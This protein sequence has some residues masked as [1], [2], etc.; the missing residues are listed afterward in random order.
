MFGRITSEFQC[1]AKIRIE[2]FI[3]EGQNSNVWKDKIK[4]PVIGKIRAQR[5]CLQ[6]QGQNSKG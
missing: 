1:S 5:Q 6:Q 3:K 4:I 2:M